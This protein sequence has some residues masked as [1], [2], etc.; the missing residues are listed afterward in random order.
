MRTLALLAALLVG[1]AHV[2]AEE[3]PNFLYAMTFK[4]GATVTR[5]AKPDYADR[6][7]PGRPEGVFVSW[8]FEAEHPEVE[9]QSQR[10]VD[11]INSAIS[12]A[13]RDRSEAVLVLTSIVLQRQ[14]IW[15]FYT[16]DGTSLAATLEQ[17]LKG[18]TRAP[19]RVRT[20]KDPDWNALNNF[21][22]RL[23]EEK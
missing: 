5:Y 8:A 2:N 21:L 12:E 10:E 6:L 11:A 3:D 23:R 19:V 16:S 9:G 7:R 18:K 13:L 20:G 1:N 15:A 14:G 4:R 17:G 22:A